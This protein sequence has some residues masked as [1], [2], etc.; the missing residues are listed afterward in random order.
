M[1]KFYPSITPTLEEWALS[2]PLFYTASAPLNGSHV[3][4][5]PKG[6]PSATFTIFSPNKAAYLDT[7]GSGSETIAH[8]YENGRVTIMFCSFGASPRIMRFFCWGRVVEHADKEFGLWVGKMGKKAE[9]VK[10][11]RAVILLDVWKVQTSCGFGVP[12][13]GTPAPDPNSDEPEFDE[14]PQ[15]LSEFPPSQ[16]SS[17]NGTSKSPKEYSFT[18]RTAMDRWATYMLTNGTPEAPNKL[19]AYQAANNTHSLDGLPALK[20][21]RKDSGERW[22]WFGDLRARGKRVVK[23]QWEGVFVGFFLGM[24]LVSLMQRWEMDFGWMGFGNV[25]TGI[26][27]GGSCRV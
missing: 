19:R 5:S 27:L 10:G 25:D 24:L 2:Q 23:G 20:A 12:I 17:S 16:T 13:Y 4:L 11:A 1:V 7:T 8:V 26:D 9:A 21:A 22:L 3:N 18:D 6:L 15:S 14:T